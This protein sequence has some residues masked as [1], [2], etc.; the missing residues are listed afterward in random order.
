MKLNEFRRIP[1]FLLLHQMFKKKLHIYVTALQLK[2]GWK[3]PNMTHIKL[4]KISQ[5]RIP[6]EINYQNQKVQYCNLC[7]EIQLRVETVSLQI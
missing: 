4:S 2:K 5:Y 3:F 7:L 1:K 6:T